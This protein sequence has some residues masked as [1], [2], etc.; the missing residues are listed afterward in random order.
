MCDFQKYAE[1]IEAIYND[2]EMIRAMRQ[3]LPSLPGKTQ[4]QNSKPKWDEIIND[5]L[6]NPPDL[7]KI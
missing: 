7:G 3:K 6:R 2:P 1:E 4:G 5:L